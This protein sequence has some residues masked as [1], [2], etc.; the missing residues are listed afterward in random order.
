MG[1][2]QRWS[3][4]RL[5]H[6]MG[7]TS[8]DID[9]YGLHGHGPDDV[10]HLL[11]NNTYRRVVRPALNDEDRHVL[12]E[13]K[14]L[15]HGLARG[16]GLPVPRTYGLYHPLR[17]V[18]PELRPFTAPQHVLRELRA[19]PPD[20]LVIKPAAGA[21][22]AGVCIYPG[23][24]VVAGRLL[25]SDGGWLGLGT[26]L[27]RLP[28]GTG[29]AMW[30]SIV[31]E[32]VAP[33]PFVARLNPHT[34]STLR[35]ITLV[36]TEGSVELLG[37]LI[38]L[39]VRGQTVDLWGEGAV[40]VPIEVGSGVLRTG[41]LRAAGTEPL[42]AHPDTGVVFAAQTLPCWDEVV[43]VC[44]RAARLLPGVDA[45]GWDLLLGVEGPVLLEANA[46]WG[47]HMPQ[48][49]LGGYL[50]SDVLREDLGRRGVE[51]PTD[52]AS[53]PTVLWRAT[54]AK[55]RAVRRPRR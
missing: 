44:R 3:R 45:V 50:A 47:L 10:S 29:A 11:G 14:W 39:G 1:V 36:T 49:N 33:H 16:A 25:T 23:A 43:A 55:L 2:R 51:L 19:A 37:A 21:K 32:L 54:A 35:V 12:T 41:R 6:G 28:A 42:E 46:G 18:T 26:A 4:A 34:P 40:S 9:V 52:A 24:D 22:S 48:R 17:G 53:A 5:I 20:G 7:F 13:N 15:F 30:G 31:Q 8:E 27:E 38:K